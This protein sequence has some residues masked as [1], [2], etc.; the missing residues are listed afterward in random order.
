[1]IQSPVLA[2]GLINTMKLISINMLGM[3]SLH[4]CK[5]V[6]SFDEVVK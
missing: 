3:P 6:V 4:S 5:L 1:M 2:T